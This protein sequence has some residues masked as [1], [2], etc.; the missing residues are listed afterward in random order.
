[1]DPLEYWFILAAVAAAGLWGFLRGFRWWR[2]ARLIEDTPT[3]RVRSAAQ[4]YVE[5]IGTARR[6]N[7]APVIAPLSKLPCTWWSYTIEQRTR[8][9]RDRVKWRVVS[10][11]VSDSLF[12]LEDGSGRC[13]VD[14]EGAEV[15]PR[16]T[17]TWYGDT[18]LPVAGPPIQRGFRGF[19]NDY[20]YRESRLH[21]GDA[22]YAIGWFRTESNVLPGAVD[23]EVAALL[24]QWKRDTA[25]LMKR[26]DTDGDGTLTLKEWERARTAAHAQVMEERLD[27]AADP[28]VHVLERSRDERP[29]LLAAGDAQALARRYRLHAVAGLAVFLAAT[30]ALA[31]LLLNSMLQGGA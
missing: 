14:P 18:S 9:S 2:W 1:V 28:G 3:S 17:D 11:R 30:A 13:I 12:Y 25:G 24:R 7:G 27:H 31:W 5:L 20:R 4:G 22:L 23:D 8:D 21:D 15:L 29:F 19:G 26:F 10:R 16:A 6:M